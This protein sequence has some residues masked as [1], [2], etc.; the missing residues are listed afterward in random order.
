[1]AHMF[2]IQEGNHLLFIIYI[3]KLIEPKKLAKTIIALRT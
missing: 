3:K 2:G 1:M